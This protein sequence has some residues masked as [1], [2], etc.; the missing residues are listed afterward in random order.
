MHCEY[1]GCK[2]LLAALGNKG[3]SALHTSAGPKTS[4]KVQ[5][6]SFVCMV[7]CRIRLRESQLG[8]LLDLGRQDAEHL[9]QRVMC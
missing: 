7:H 3:A 9:L 2:L 6:S 5:M 4:Q 1:R 8:P